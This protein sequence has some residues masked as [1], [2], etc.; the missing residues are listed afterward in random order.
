MSVGRIL[1][2]ASIVQVVIST[3]G[4]ESGEYREN[5]MA[6]CMTSGHS[7]VGRALDLRSSGWQKRIFSQI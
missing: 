6:H 4:P 3:G 2:R 5:A 7:A 1:R